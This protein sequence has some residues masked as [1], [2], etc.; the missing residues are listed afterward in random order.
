M[1]SFK[2]K[3]GIYALCNPETD[4]VMYVGQ[5]IDL[6]YRSRTH[7]TTIHGNPR[8][9]TWMAKLSRLGLEPKVLT[10]EQCSDADLNA[11]EKKWVRYFKGRGEAELNVSVGGETR[12]SSKLLNTHPDDWCQFA[13]KVR[14]AYRLLLEIQEQA[15][16]LTSVKNYDSMRGLT[17]K[18]RLVIQKI[19]QQLREKF[20]SGSTFHQHSSLRFKVS[21][22]A[23]LKPNGPLHVDGHFE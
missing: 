21:E 20:L 5:S 15:L 8:W 7:W 6:D 14:D 2:P 22:F 18:W 4:R 3:I 16:Q 11:A 13:L 17:L 23:I 19:E 1:N 10:L 9:G 12:I